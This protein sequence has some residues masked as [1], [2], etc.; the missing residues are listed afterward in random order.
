[1]STSNVMQYEQTGNKSLSI[2]GINI[3]DHMASHRIAMHLLHRHRVGLLSL[4]GVAMTGQYL[5]EHVV[6]LFI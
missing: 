1:M 5:Y 3:I 6:K 2:D 4:Y